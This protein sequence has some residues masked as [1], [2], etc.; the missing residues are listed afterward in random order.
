MKGNEGKG[1]IG[2]GMGI[3]MKENRG[4]HLR[5]RGQVNV[6]PSAW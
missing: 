5:E 2:I 4:R 3:E 1:K 6:V